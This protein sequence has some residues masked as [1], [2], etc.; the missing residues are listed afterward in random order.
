M[1]CLN[2]DDAIDR[3]ALLAA[4]RSFTADPAAALDRFVDSGRQVFAALRALGLQDAVPPCGRRY[5]IPTDL[6]N[7]DK[8]SGMRIDH[9]LVNGQ[10]EV[11]CGEVYHSAATNRASDH[12]PVIVEF[13]IKSLAS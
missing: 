10:I 8:S 9:I 12:H 1:N 2:P 3:R 11:L 4:F 6:L 13:Q 5:T 7:A